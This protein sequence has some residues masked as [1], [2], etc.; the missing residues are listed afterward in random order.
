MIELILA[1]TLMVTAVFTLISVFSSS[2]RH[3]VMSRNRT[4]AILLAHSYMEEFKAH[5]YGRRPP[6]H[7]KDP[8]ESPVTVYVEGHPQLMEFR[9]TMRFSNGSFVGE[10][11][12]DSDEVTLKI[13]W[14]EGIGENNGRKE[15]SIKVPVWR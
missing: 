5:P 6:K 12:G 15:M 13:E 11:Q 10:G 14:N 4:V 1:M 8:L 3:A 9:K 2:S 7:W